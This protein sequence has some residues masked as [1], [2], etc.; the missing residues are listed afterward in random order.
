M[1]LI[2][3]LCAF[4]LILS[5]SACAADKPKAVNLGSGSFGSGSSGDA[6]ATASLLQL[7][8][9]AHYCALDRGQVIDAM[10]MQVLDKYLEGI[11]QLLAV[12]RD[13]AALEASR[14][15]I[16]D[17]STPMVAITAVVQNGMPVRPPIPRA[18]LI[19]QFALLFSELAKS[20][21]F[22][23]AVDAEARKRFDNTVGQLAK[24]FGSS[25]ELGESS[26]FDVRGQDESAVYIGMINGLDSGN[27]HV[28]I[29]NIVAVTVLNGIV[30]E[31]AF[32]SDYD[33]DPHLTT[34]LATA[35]TIMRQLVNANDFP[36]HIDI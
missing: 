23:E 28:V 27:R 33:N 34:L 29:G 36:N 31:V 12:W 18:T 32:F 24:Q 11:A 21:D 26:G 15:G 5:L 30:V 20:N 35:R 10:A 22:N 16:S 8:P 4:L 25:A 9:P 3:S 19:Q 1:P 13:C 17:Y 14:R 7:K 6:A 2:R